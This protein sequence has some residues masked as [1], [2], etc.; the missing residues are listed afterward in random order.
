MAVTQLRGEPRAQDMYA[1]ARRRGKSKKEAMRTLKRNLSNVVH[2][3]MVRDF[4][5]SR[6]LLRLVS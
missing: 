3:R 2:R 5:A 4:E 6:P 1:D